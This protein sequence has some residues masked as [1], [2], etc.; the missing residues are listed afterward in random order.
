MHLLYVHRQLRVIIKKER[1]KKTKINDS[2]MS[3]DHGHKI[4]D[5][6]WP[7]IWIVRVHSLKR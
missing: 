3:T 2:I 4:I 6:R 1:V 5:H 7:M